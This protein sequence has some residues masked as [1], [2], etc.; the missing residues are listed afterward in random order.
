MVVRKTSVLFS[1]ALIAMTCSYSLSALAN[2]LVQEGVSS[3]LELPK[4][5]INAAPLVGQVAV[6]AVVGDD[7]ITTL[8][9]KNRLGLAVVATGMGQDRE[10][11]QRLLPQ[12]MQGL[13]NE[14]LYMQEAKRLKIIIDNAEVEKGIEVLSAQNHQSTEAFKRMF[15]D[16]GIPVSTLEDKIRGEIL[17]GKV[18]RKTISPKVRVSD[19]E[20]DEVM[21]QMTLSKSER[22]VGI[23]QILLPIDDKTN[24]TKISE[25]ASNIVKEIRDGKS[26]Q[27]MARQFS[28]TALEHKEDEIAWVQESQLDE[29]LVGAIHK[30]KEG[31]VSDPIRTPDGYLIVKL[32]GTKEVVNVHGDN[33][34]L[35]MKQLFVPIPED[36]SKIPQLKEQLGQLRETLKGCENYEKIDQSSIDGLHVDTMTIGLNDIHPELRS[37]VEEQP[38]GKVGDIVTT[39]VGLHVVTVCERSLPEKVLPEREKI[40]Q[41]VQF[42]KIELKAKHYL[43]DL[44]RKTYIEIKE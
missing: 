40:R 11:Q 9:V 30:L 29:I 36:K 44:R 41:M 7:I 23:E 42:K 25:L 20:V 2:L 17:W 8:D 43:R 32:D 13:I 21:E 31:E 24:S 10:S 33:A 27:A 3:S 15:E 4:E 14:R 39:S 37:V 18:V 5:S 34:Q 22:M 38:V 35:T 16:N 28:P 12:I 6:M 1:G 19:A 26:F